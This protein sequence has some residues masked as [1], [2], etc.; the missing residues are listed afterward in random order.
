MQSALFNLK[1]IVASTLFVALAL[2][3]MLHAGATGTVTYQGKTWTVADAVAAQTFMGY[4]LS[5]SPQPWDRA[6]WA[7][8]GKFDSLDIGKFQEEKETQIFRIDLSSDKSYVVV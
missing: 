1:S 7:E 3:N 5:F 4:E 8:D 2:P 6:A